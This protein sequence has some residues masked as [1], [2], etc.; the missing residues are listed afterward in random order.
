MFPHLHQSQPS[1]GQAPAQT[2]Q[3]TSLPPLLQP[4]RLPELIVAGTGHH[5]RIEGAVE[6]VRELMLNVESIHFSSL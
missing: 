2:T 6:H 5:E 3:G 1:H 4:A